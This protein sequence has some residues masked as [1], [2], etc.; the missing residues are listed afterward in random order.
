MKRFLLSVLLFASLV[1]LCLAAVFAWRVGKQQGA[2]RKSLAVRPDQSILFIGDSHIG[3]S[4]VEEPRF[5][6]RIVWA[7]SLPQSFTLMRLLDMERLG[8]LSPVRTLVLELG[9][10]NFGQHDSELLKVHTLRSLG[11]AWR[12]LDKVPLAPMELYPFLITH[13]SGRMFIVDKPPTHTK[14]LLDQP[15]A[16]RQ[17]DLRATLDRAFKW[18]QHPETLAPNWQSALKET[19]AEIQ[20]L[21]ARHNIRVVCFTAPVSSF[22]REATPPESTALL[23]HFADFLRARGIPYYDLSAW[24]EDRDFYDCTH[25]S[26]PAAARFTERFYR[27]ILQEPID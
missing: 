15:E 26:L 22:Y 14:S 23:Q 8:T 13:L 3:C 11:F 2:L 21:C 20:A 9:V 12:H 25:L 7:S 27:E 18:H 10:Q 24:C 5:H 19:F 16:L 17:K 6:N 1:G 4:F